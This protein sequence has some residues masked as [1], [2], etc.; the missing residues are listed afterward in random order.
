MNRIESWEK[1]IHATQEPDRLPVLDYDVWFSDDPDAFQRPISSHVPPAPVHNSRIR[2][3]FRQWRSSLENTLL[4]PQIQPNKS[5][6]RATAALYT[7]RVHHGSRFPQSNV[8]TSDLE[9]IYAE[10]GE[11]ISG[12]CEL[13]QA[14]KYN[15]ITPRTYFAQGGK[16]FHASKY[17]RQPI[18]SLA[19][20]F[21]ETNFQ[22]RFS[23]HEM[24]IDSNDLAFV[25]DY[26]S[27]TSLLAELKYFL[28]AL[29]DFCQ[30]TM[31]FLVDSHAGI[32]QRSLGDILREYNQE[33]N[34]KGEFTINRYEDGN[35]IPLSHQLAGFLGV[36]GN[37]TS[38][39]TLHGLHACQI[40]GDHSRCRCVGDDVF[41][42]LRPTRDYPKED[43]V[44]AIQTLGVVQL[45]KVRWWR[46]I[47]PDNEEDED[48]A[49]PYLKRP[50]DRFG[51]RMRL[52]AALFLP[53]WGLICPME[54]ILNREVED[55]YTRVKL[56][57]TQTFSAIKQAQQLYPPLEDHQKEF[58]RIYLE[59]M[60]DFL[61]LDT[62]GRLPCES[63]R[64]NNRVVT[65]LFVPNVEPGFLD[66]DPWDILASRW[67]A[68]TIL[69]VPL[70]VREAENNLVRALEDPGTTHRSTMT[71]AATYLKSMGWL[72]ADPI[73][74][75]VLWD[76]EEYRRFY[77]S[78]FAGELRAMYEIRLL[79]RDVVII[80]D[81]ALYYRL[82]AI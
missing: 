80:N 71:R 4:F 41:G 30:D 19:D 49:Y 56:L 53:I 59:S 32:L 17:I 66:L 62:K 42:V 54:D 24:P 81:L 35:N 60:Y 82:D 3:G 21:P 28:A 37:I 74:I 65:N 29:A 79:R 73:R 22:S 40:C 5:V 8:S 15:D 18:N 50:L 43:A 26:T 58:L 2:L 27:F 7:E 46:Y 11:E 64:I 68:N 23:I 72:M 63:F 70:M 36:Y 69:S 34:I 48:R 1:E 45:Q 77:T 16:A 14:W 6:S 12:P 31:V 61:G 20:A 10:T 76:F 78:V 52:E 57:A 13:R 44:K 38:S 51:N 33:C 39:T 55:T 75:D 67:H 25:Y 47:N 9:R